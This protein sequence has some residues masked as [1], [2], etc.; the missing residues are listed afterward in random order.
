VRILVIGLGRWGVKH[1]RVLDELGVEVWVAE[2][3]E[4]R[5]R[6]ALASGIGP[7]R[8]HADFRDGLPHVDAVDVV[9][10]A[11]SHLAVAG[12]C[13]RAGKPCFVEK[14]LA[15]TIGEARELAGIVTATGGLLQVGHVFRFHPVA[16]AL[17]ERLDRDT[18]GR[19]RYCTGRFAGFKRPRNDVGITQTDAI[20]FFDLFAALLRRA[21][22]AVTAALRDYLG[23]GLDDCAFAAVEYGEVT[24]FI[25]A[26]YFA[27]RTM[28]ECVIVGEGATLVGDFSAS[29]VHVYPNRHVRGSA[30]WQVSEGPVEVIEAKGPE[31]LR[32]E[33]AHFLDVVKRGASPSVNVADGLRSLRTVTAARMSSE[34]GRRVLLE[35]AG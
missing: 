5:R 7:D 19:V 13:L 33:L 15:A 26:S 28:R 12:H 14:P 2:R 16:E 24:A 9:T 25:E 1:L 32:E 27:P 29:T 6:L 17:Q 23:R 3:S 8:V 34:L 21:P 4:D 30:A 35:E 18:V 11:D 10:P 31:P 20:H 22:T